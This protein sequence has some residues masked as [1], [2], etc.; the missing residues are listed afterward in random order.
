[1]RG[2]GVGKKHSSYKGLFYGILPLFN[3]GW[4]L[5]FLPTIGW[6]MQELANVLFCIKNMMLGHLKL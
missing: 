3:E 4:S 6:A 2:E 5:Y 1:M